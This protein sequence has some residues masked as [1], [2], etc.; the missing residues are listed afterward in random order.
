MISG[1]F[2]QPLLAVMLMNAF[3]SPGSE[4]DLIATIPYPLTFFLWPFVYAFLGG[5]CLCSSPGKR[6]LGLKVYTDVTESMS[7]MHSGFREMFRIIEVVSIF[8]GLLSLTNLIKGEP[9]ATD[10]IFKT[11]V[12]ELQPV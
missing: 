5:I 12:L 11:T 9:T 10:Q 7:R 4:F 8:L 3:G 2:L 1:K 6:L